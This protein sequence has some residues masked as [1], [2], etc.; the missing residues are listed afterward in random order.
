[1]NQEIFRKELSKHK[2]LI[3]QI[4]KLTEKELQTNEHL[5]KIIRAKKQAR[6]LSLA[7]NNCQCSKCGA[8]T[9]LSYHHFILKPFRHYMDYSRWVTARTYWSNLIILC[10]PCHGEIHLVDR[11]EPVENESRISQEVINKV[12]SKYNIILSEVIE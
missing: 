3:S 2:K 11:K 5:H 12:I 1:M 7:Y 9:R 8:Q 4:G 6:E 10:W